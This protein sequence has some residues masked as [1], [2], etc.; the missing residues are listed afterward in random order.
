MKV[1][2]ILHTY[3]IIVTNAFV[4]YIK[5]VNT[6]FF[7]GTDTHNKLYHKMKVF[8][9]LHTYNIIVTNAFVLS[10]LICIEF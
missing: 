3:N 10:T 7:L 2:T 5:N 1:F 8:T 4:L 6:I 9:I